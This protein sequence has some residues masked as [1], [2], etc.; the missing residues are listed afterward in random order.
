MRVMNVIG[1]LGGMAFTTIG[2]L[3]I[4]F[5]DCRVTEIFPV[6]AARSLDPALRVTKSLTEMVEEPFALSCCECVVGP[7]GVLWVACSFAVV[8][9]IAGALASRIGET[10]SPWRGALA[11]GLA[12]GAMLTQF[13][14]S[15]N[16]IDVT[17]TMLVGAGAML[18]AIACAYGAAYFAIRNA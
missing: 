11:V 5:F 9:M 14:T 2:L 3:C 17:Q 4:S 1:L 16:E 6:R 7:S 12:F 13:A 8:F 15:A 18:G 10:S